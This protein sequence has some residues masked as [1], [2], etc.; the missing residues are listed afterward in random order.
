M[1]SLIWPAMHQEEGKAMN[2]DVFVWSDVMEDG[3]N[4]DSNF[5]L[6]GFYKYTPTYTFYVYCIVYLKHHKRNKKTDNFTL[7][8]RMFIFYLSCKC[9][10]RCC[11][12]A[13]A[14]PKLSKVGRGSLP[15]AFHQMK[16]DKHAY[17]VEN[18]CLASTE[19][20]Q[21]ICWATYYFRL[22]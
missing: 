10:G 11:K 15:L 18:T 22:K 17:T 7:C 21:W 16:W 19:F 8:S 2:R 9:C 6:C 3:W 4:K 20:M 5:S 14:Q 12:P 13:S 1:P